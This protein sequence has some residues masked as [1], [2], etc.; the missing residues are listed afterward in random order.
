MLVILNIGE[1][2]VIP[3]GPVCGRE[4]RNVRRIQN[5]AIVVDGGQISWFGRA[6]DVLIPPG[7]DVLDAGGGCVLPGLIDC[8]TH[9]VFA[10]TRENEFVQRIEGKSY[11]DIAREGGGIR[12]TVDAV[13]AATLEQLIALALPRLSRM[14][15]NGVTSLEIKSGYGL[16]VDDEFKMLESVRRLREFQPIELVG[17]YLSAHA[18]PR[19]FDGHTD[20]YLGRMLDDPVLSRI[21][22]GRL[23]EFCDVFCET[24]A[25]N[26]EQS[27][28]VLLKAK[29]FGL[30]PKIHADQIT[31]MGA[32]R[33][34]AEGG[35]ISADHLEKIDDGGIAAL[36]AVGTIAVLLPACS[37]FLGVEQAPA[38]KIIEADVPVA[39]ATDYNPGS[40]M[41]ESL[42]LTM[43]IAC[44][45]M[46]MTPIEVVVAATANAAAAIGRQDRIGA[47]DIGMQ[48]DLIVLDV[49]SVERWMYE[50]GRNCLRTVLKR[51]KVVVDSSG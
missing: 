17:T 6:T 13:R 41:V 16:S 31:Q 36:K 51:G 26:I 30:L 12:V 23:A 47:I 39:I 19:E 28:R 7:S 21:R 5:A 37:F 9:G 29:Q 1:L 24:T 27:R 33:L 43:T 11:A 35:A 45:Q 50:P 38:R 2:V 49:P 10:G 22:D 40:S 8:H 44:T 48:A 42:P 46:R 4:M 14:L 25:F 20:E 18:V 15:H 3:K 34:A 32:S